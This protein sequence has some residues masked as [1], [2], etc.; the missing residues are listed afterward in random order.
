[1]CIVARREAVRPA[2]FTS[3]PIGTEREMEMD[4]KNRW[5]LNDQNA[6]KGRPFIIR[7]AWEKNPG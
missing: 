7:Q 1:M 5:K 3:A 4:E 6:S 2:A